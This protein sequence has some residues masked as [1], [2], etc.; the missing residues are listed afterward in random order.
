MVVMTR[1]PE[2]ERFADIQLLHLLAGRAGLVGDQLHAEHAGGF[3][4][5]LVEVRAELDAAAL[6]ATAG[7]DLRLDHP[8]AVAQLLGGF[9]RLVDAGGDM[10][11]R[12]GDAGLLEQ[13]RGLIVMDVHG[14]MSFGD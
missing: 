7:M 1:W 6:A 12:G 11:V 10:A 5:H 8:R 9:D 13:R 4:A 3:F 2:V 14:A